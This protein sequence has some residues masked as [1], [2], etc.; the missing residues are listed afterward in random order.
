MFPLPGQSPAQ[1]DSNEWPNVLAKGTS[2][3]G[4]IEVADS[5]RL[6]GTFDGEVHTEGTLFVVP[7]AHVEGTIQASIVVIGGNFKG[8]IVC[9][10]RVD[11]EAAC[12]ASG[13]L[14]T[15]ALTVEEGALFDGDVIM[16]KQTA[17]VSRVASAD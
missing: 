13:S 4:T 11:L 9:E 10:R 15:R 8:D 12:R 14:T 3:S 7:E 16:T 2:F 1:S 17:P 6:E 5:I